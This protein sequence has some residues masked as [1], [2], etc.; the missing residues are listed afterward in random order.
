MGRRMDAP[1]S[2]AAVRAFLE[3]GHTELDTA[4][5]YSD[6]Q[7]ESILG[8]LGLG[9]GGGDCRGN[10]SLPCTLRRPAGPSRVPAARPSRAPTSRQ[11]RERLA[12]DSRT[13]FVLT[14]FLSSFPF[15]EDRPGPSLQQCPTQVQSGTPWLALLGGT[16]RVGSGAVQCLPPFPSPRGCPVRAPSARTLPLLFWHSLAQPRI[17]LWDGWEICILL[18]LGPRLCSVE[19]GVPRSVGSASHFTRLAVPGSAWQ[20]RLLSGQ[21]RQDGRGEVVAFLTALC[22]SL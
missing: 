19:L 1:A 10:L 16:E 6:G 21:S 3:R 9:L 14:S 18:A 15:Q 8:G 20:L 4:F 17:R 11:L 13:S 22:A 2:A 7:S 12:P 5:M